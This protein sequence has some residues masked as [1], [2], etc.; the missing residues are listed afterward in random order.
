MPKTEPEIIELDEK[1]RAELRRRLETET[2]RSEDHK[3]LV[4]ALDTLAYLEDIIKGKKL[5]IAR[6]HKLVFGSSS[7]KTD[8]VLDD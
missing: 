7:E 4:A 3:I 2:L 6:L 5:S 8:A 1:T